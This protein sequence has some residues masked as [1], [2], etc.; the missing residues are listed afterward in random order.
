SEAM[1]TDWLRVDGVLQFS[2]DNNHMPFK[3]AG[4]PMLGLLSWPDTLDARNWLTEDGRRRRITSLSAASEIDNPYF[5]VNRNN[6][7]S[8]TNR[9]NV[10]V[11][12]TL[13]PVT[14]ANFK[15]QIGVDN[16]SQ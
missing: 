3:G 12:L 9:I 10:N 2:T 6:T 13:L 1:A 8:R 15:T 7:Q 4:G 14:W 11:G 5:S 16:Y